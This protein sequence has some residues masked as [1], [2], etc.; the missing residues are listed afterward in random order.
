MCSV[1]AC[2]EPFFRER[3]DSRTDSATPA[4][5][6]A[7]K[8]TRYIIHS[9]PEESVRVSWSSEARLKARCCGTLPAPALAVQQLHTRWNVHRLRSVA[10]S[11]AF[12][13]CRRLLPPLKKQTVDS[14]RS[15]TLACCFEL[16]GPI[17]DAVAAVYVM[18]WPRSSFTCGRKVQKKGLILRALSLPF[19]CAPPCPRA[20]LQPTT[21]P[22]S[23]RRRILSSP[24][25]RFYAQSGFWRLCGEGSRRR[26]E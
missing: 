22:Y 24:P 1:R 19:S 16:Y 6:L 3:A 15:A 4:R 23:H 18:V 20:R 21:S 13:G 17:Q 26:E 5:L 10:A 8:D 11:A 7:R 9:S 14:L 2:D 25:S 12:A